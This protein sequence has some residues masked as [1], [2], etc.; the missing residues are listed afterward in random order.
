M[1]SQRTRLSRSLE[2]AI[3]AAVR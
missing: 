1:S 3:T 2:Q